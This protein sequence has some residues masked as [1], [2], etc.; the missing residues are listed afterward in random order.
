MKG[1]AKI[2]LTDVNTGRVKTFEHDNLITNAVKNYLSPIVAN[3]HMSQPYSAKCTSIIQRLFGGL[4]LFDTALEESVDNTIP[5]YGVECVG[6]GSNIAYNGEDTNL[7]SF[8]DAESVLSGDSVKF[9]WDFS[10]SQGNGTI[11]SL[12]LTNFSAGRN[13]LGQDVYDSTIASDDLIT[14]INASKN[15]NA[16]FSCSSYST[17]YTTYTKNVLH[18]FY[19]NTFSYGSSDHFLTSGKIKIRKEYR[20]IESVILNDLSYEDIEITVPDEIL[21]YYS[22]VNGITFSAVGKY[23]YIHITS[24]G[25]Y[26][27]SDTSTYILK[28]DLDDY[29][30]ET[31]KF[32]NKTGVGLYNAIKIMDGYIYAIE[33]D[34]TTKVYKI[35]IDDNSDI[36]EIAGVSGNYVT[37]GGKI[38]NDILATNNKS[39]VFDLSQNKFRRVAGC[40]FSST[41][42]FSYE[43]DMEHLLYAVT[44]TDPSVYMLKN[45][46]YLATIN[47][48]SSPVTKT[49]A[50]TMK[51]TYTL[52]AV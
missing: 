42:I 24:G 30:T 21:N 50:Q 31:I 19:Y 13:G 43:P 39:Y 11:A 29:S 46:Y 47:N 2:E 34:D 20:S 1:H 32:T 40:A 36:T 23:V 35:N 9:V 8:N 28:I 3:G 10:T 18:R 17:Y 52:T 26:I 15:T 16:A 6:R 5:P 12:A 4:F 33:R 48:L 45:T 41:Y 37:V 14:F 25:G 27:A 49:S 38:T 51:V 22:S 44:G 7:G